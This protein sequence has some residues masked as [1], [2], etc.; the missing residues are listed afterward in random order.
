MQSISINPFRLLSESWRFLLK[1]PALLSVLFW[2]LIAPAVLLDMVRLYWPESDI[3]SVRRIGTTG[4]IVAQVVLAFLFFWG[5][6]SVLLVGRRMV[7]SMAGRSRTSFR[8]VRRESL[9]MI[10]PLF[11]TSLLRAIVTLEWAFLAAIPAMMFLLGSQTCRAT[12]SPFISAFGTFVNTGTIGF[13]DPVLRKIPMRCGPLLIALPLLLPAAVYQ[14]RT[15]FFGVIVVSENLLYRD[16]LRRSRDIVRGRTWSVLMT[17]LV[18]AVSLYAPSV[19]LS[20]AVGALLQTASP[21]AVLFGA[22]AKDIVYAVATLLFILALTAFY[23]KLRREAGR[24]EE[25]VPEME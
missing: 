7:K 12:V 18:M 6:A 20:F 2:L 10:F 25:V 15:A 17:I 5:F 4:F 14:I 11:F 19:I 13:L 16:A 23:G 8:S 22:V 3:E 21:D 24:V 1:Q 9:R